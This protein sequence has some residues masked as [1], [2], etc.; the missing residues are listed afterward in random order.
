LR[1]SERGIFCGL[2]EF[3][4]PLRHSFE[5]AHVRIIHTQYNLLTDL[6]MQVYPQGKPLSP[7][8]LQN[9]LSH[10]VQG[11]VFP[12][13]VVIAPLKSHK[14]IPD[15]GS[16]KYLMSQCAVFLIASVHSIFVLLVNFNYFA[17]LNILLIFNILFDDRQWRAANGGYEIRVRPQS[18]ESAFQSGKLLAKQK[19]TQTLDPLHKFM[20]TQLRINFAK[21][22]NVI[23][24]DLKFDYF[25]FQ[26]ISDLLNDFLQP[27][28]YTIHKHSAAILRTEN[29][30]VLTG[31]ENML[32]AFV[33]L[34]RGHG[35]N[36]TA[37]HCIVRQDRALYPHALRR[38]F[39]GASD[40]CGWT[41]LT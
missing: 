20:N 38:G 2:P 12:A 37:I 31:V 1:E 19:R 36:Y 30:M 21:N 25:A 4:A 3:W 11:N 39:Y 35:D 26:F 22:M 41:I 28:I 10:L 9:M 27:N 23:G 13:Q 34:L 40:K 15:R 33:C 17:Q 8:Q 32:V 6:R 29:N 18:R 7:S 24:H 14:M 5:E 16:N